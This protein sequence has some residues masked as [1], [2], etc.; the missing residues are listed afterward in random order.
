MAN[1]VDKETL[2][3]EIVKWQD[4]R[5]AAAARE[6]E[7]PVMPDMIAQAIMET[8]YGMGN[9]WNFKDYS[10][11][12]EMILD[13]IEAALKAV[14]KFDRDHPKKNPFGFISFVIWRAFV[15]RIRSEKEF[16]AFKMEMALDETIAAYEKA[17]GDDDHDVSKAGM[18][19]QY[20]LNER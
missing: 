5:L 3:D 8:A 9:R 17:D 11:V 15:I 14:A 13:G 6:E 18:I 16:Q 4:A 2:Y 20:S 1:Y 12:D 7:L 10:W 19:E